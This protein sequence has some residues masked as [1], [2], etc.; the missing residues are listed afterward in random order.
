MVGG[1]GAGDRA[2]GLAIKNG[3]V[4]GSK[5]NQIKS[6]EISVDQRQDVM[7]LVVFFYCQVAAIQS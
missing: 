6:N 1:Q 3:C 4:T 5:S 2:R 7:M